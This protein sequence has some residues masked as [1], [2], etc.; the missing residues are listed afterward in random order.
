[1]S[2]VDLNNNSQE[3]DITEIPPPVVELEF[4]QLSPGQYTFVYFDLETTGLGK[5]NNIIVSPLSS[6]AKHRGNFC[7]VWQLHHLFVFSF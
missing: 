1:M 5:P 7:S 6:E 3:L 2:G 4:S